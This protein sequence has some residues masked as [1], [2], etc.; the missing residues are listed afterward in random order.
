MIEPLPLQ[1]IEAGDLVEGVT[2]DFKSQLNLDARDATS[3]LV[4]D[5]V[6]FLNRGEARIVMGIEERGGAFSRYR[7]LTG[8]PD[9]IALR[10]LQS[11]QDNIDPRPLHLNVVPMAVDG[12]FLLDVQIPEHVMRPYQNRLNGAFQ[13]RTGARNR[14]LGRDEI[15]ALFVKPEA[16]ER[17]LAQFEEREE[18]LLANRTDVAT[19]GAVLTVSVLPQE[20]YRRSHPPYR[21]SNGVMK[22]APLFSEKRGGFLAPCER[23]HEIL[24]PSFS[25]GNIERLFVGHDWFIHA[26]IVFPIRGD[27]QRVFIPE[28]AADLNVYIRGLQ[29]WMA[30]QG[31]RGPFC[32]S[33]RIKHLDRSPRVAWVFPNITTV[34]LPH[35]WYGEN[36]VEAGLAKSFS[37]LV[38]RSSRF[39]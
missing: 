34:S 28:F 14:A 8:D 7:P 20:F 27:G 36:M 18:Q 3:N 25:D 9:K 11:I 32:V 29:E 19:T 33:L 2:L 24:E 12:G 6:A 1:Q 15:A 30:E 39:G 10:L 17:D 22:A 26:H 38:T 37:D 23:G 16:Y 5:V 13:I 31:L 21:R 4:D 35:P